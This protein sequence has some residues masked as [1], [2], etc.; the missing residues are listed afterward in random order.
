VADRRARGVGASRLV[1]IVALVVALLS[2][3]V[4]PHRADAHAVLLETTPAAGESLASAPASVTLRFSETI[5]LVRPEDVSV[6][7]ED[8]R[9]VTEGDPARAPSNSRVVVAP[10]RAGLA[11]GTFTVRYRILSADAHVVS[12]LYAFG[13]GSGPIGPPVSEGAGRGPAESGGWAVSARLLEL[14]GIGGLFGLIAFRWLVW[15]PA[16]RGT[17]SLSP[18]ESQAALE[19]LRD[20]FWGVFAVLAI[21][22][23]VA[24][25]YLL[26]VKS[27]SLLGTTVFGALADPAGVSRALSETPFG[28]QVQLRAAILVVLF[29]TGLVQSAVESQSAD[30]DRPLRPGGRPVAGAVMAACALVVLGSISAQG[31]ASQAPWSPL[32][33]GADAIHLAAAAVWIAGLAM[34]LTVLR[35]APRVAPD[36]GPLLAART[37]ARFSRV[38]LVSVGLAIATGTIRTIG[39]LSDP[40][41]LWQ[42]GHGRSIVIKLALLCPIGFLSFRNR[43]IVT[44]LRTVSRPNRPTLQMVR[45]G[46]ALEIGLSLAVVVVAALLVGQ[47]P[48]R[49]A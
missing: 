2:A 10:L 1:A 22:S 5:H 14:V 9:P 28:S 47:V 48:G 46:V 31:H 49:L 15:A 40:A 43:R 23:L 26:F 8:G 45:R 37:L 39:E 25:A 4:A 17:P 35:R 6:V 18:A 32:S 41:E 19:W 21:G 42:T 20:R 13:V 44:A 38:A 30:G 11:E 7:D 16:H 12:G 36:G 3:L 29:A 33:I 24:E 34:T 27:A